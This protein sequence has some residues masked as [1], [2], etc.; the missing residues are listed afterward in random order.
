MKAMYAFFLFMS[1]FNL[2]LAELSGNDEWLARAR[3]EFILVQGDY[4][5]ISIQE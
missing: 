3:E 4:D 5:R 1:E 2:R